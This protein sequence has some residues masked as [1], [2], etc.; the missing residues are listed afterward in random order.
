MW[1]GFREAGVDVFVVGWCLVAVGRTNGGVLRGE[2]DGFNGGLLDWGEPATI[3][4]RGCL[5]GLFRGEVALILGPVCSCR[6][7]VPKES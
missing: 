6:D 1:G 7:V 3:A 4:T 5:D 2:F